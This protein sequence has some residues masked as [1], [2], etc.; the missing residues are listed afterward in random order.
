L[1]SVSFVVGQLSR[2]LFISFI[3]SF[4]WLRNFLHR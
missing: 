1:T 4:P 2:V 3:V